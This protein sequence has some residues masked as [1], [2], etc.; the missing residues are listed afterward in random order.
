MNS[1]TYQFEMM[2]AK[3]KKQSI[4]IEGDFCRDFRKLIKQLPLLKMAQVERKLVGLE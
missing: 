3:F 2:Q 1:K 4:M